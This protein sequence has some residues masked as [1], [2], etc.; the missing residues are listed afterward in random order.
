[1]ALRALIK[2]LAGIR[3]H[4]LFFFVATLRTGDDGLENHIFHS[5]I[6]PAPT[7]WVSR[8]V[9]RRLGLLADDE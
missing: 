9:R 7:L 5:Y 3:G 1:M 2:P 6:F 4:L 8:A